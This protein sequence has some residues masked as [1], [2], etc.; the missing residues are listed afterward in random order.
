MIH[1]IESH[2]PYAQ[3]DHNHRTVHT[4]L[5]QQH[6]S[7]SIQPVFYC[8]NIYCNYFALHIWVYMILLTIIIFFMQN[9]IAAAITSNTPTPGI[10][11]T[12]NIVRDCHDRSNFTYVIGD[13]YEKLITEV[14][15][16][17]CSEIVELLHFIIIVEVL[18]I[19]MFPLVITWVWSVMM[20]WHLT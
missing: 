4:A 5:A 8:F 19:S 14:R 18:Q 15:S 16:I 2:W 10:N 1:N 6:V 11:E 17:M 20:V 3:Y 9:Y 7:N 13:Y 12:T